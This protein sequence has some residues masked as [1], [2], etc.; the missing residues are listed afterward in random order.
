MVIRRRRKNPAG[1]FNRTRKFVFMVSLS[2]SFLFF[3]SL[4]VFVFVFFFFFWP[5]MKR[6]HSSH[7]DTQSSR[8]VRPSQ[9]CESVAWV[10]AWLFLLL[11]F[12]SSRFVRRLS[13]DRVEIDRSLA[14]SLIAHAFLSTFPRRTAKTHPTLQDFNFAG[15]FFHHL[16]R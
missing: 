12:L 16:H 11:L 7:A 13:G 2:L 9:S 4:F 10:G 1:V 15:H 6:D 5:Y 3:Y 14:A 8:C